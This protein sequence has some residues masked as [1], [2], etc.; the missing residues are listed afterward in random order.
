[1]PETS[2]LAR[3][4]SPSAS[5]RQRRAVRWLLLTAL[6][7]AVTVGCGDGEDRVATSEN[8][9][10]TTT[11]EMTTT[12]T[13]TETTTT[14]EGPTFDQA[15]DRL[16]TGDPAGAAEML[17][18]VTEREPENGRAWSFLGWA[19]RQSDDLEGALEAYQRA[20][21]LSAEARGARYGLAAIQAMMGHGDE[22][23]ASLAAL[24]EEGRYDLS[25][26]STDEDFSSLRDDPRFGD[27]LMKPE[28]FEQP[29]VESTRVLHEWRGETAG[30]EFGWIARNI[31]D[32]DGD[33]VADLTTSAPNFGDAAGRVYV[34]SGK[35]GEGLW[36]ADGSD[37][38]LLGQGIEAAGDVNADGVPDVVVGAPGGDYVRVYS[39]RDG[40][41]LRTLEG[42]EGEAYGRMVSDVGDVDGDGHADLMIGAPRHDAAGEDAG[43]VVI[44]SGA[45]GS[46]LIEWRGEVAGA[47]FGSAGAGG[48][49]GDGVILV[50]GAPDAGEA[51]RGRVYVYGGLDPAPAFVI[52]SDAEGSELGGM[53]VSVLGDVDGDGLPDVYASDWA[54][55]GKGPQTGRVVVH[56]SADG[57]NLLT[58]PGEAKGDGF[59]I[60]PA[61]AGDVDGDGRADLIVGA[62]QQGN[63]APAGGKVYLISGADGATLRSWTCRV[64]GDTFG[65]DA[66]GMGD[67]DGDGATDFLLTS[68]WSAVNGPRSGRMFLLA[69][70]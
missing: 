31:G 37:G 32:V 12:E 29:F 58:L 65:F 7:P 46:T 60:G 11:A 35:G 28:D 42:E 39:G 67:V 6:L 18:A 14:V 27:L 64:M 57:H 52:D 59:G 61:D 50:V 1:M 69:G 68:A 26:L 45:D 44:V 49:V 16:R 63:G 25:Q 3:S 66:T 30:D 5:T 36:Q 2:L 48:V 21:E 13:T 22:A 55:A 17:A 43:R 41:V 47:R 9:A 56:S 19:R 70:E 33:G 62:W 8:G 15:I 54:H 20:V 53:F 51:Q 38:D 4:S 24:R 40:R 10:E 23:L 34:Y